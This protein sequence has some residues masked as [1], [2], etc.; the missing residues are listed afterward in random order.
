MSGPLQRIFGANDKIKQRKEQTEK[1]IKF[2]HTE[3]MNFETAIRGMR[4]PLNSWDK[5]DSTVCEDCVAEIEAY[6]ER[7]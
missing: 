1:M 6:M 4:N 7:G 3:V 5:M 2:E